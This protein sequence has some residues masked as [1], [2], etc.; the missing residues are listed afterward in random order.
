[1]HTS[2]LLVHNSETDSV[3]S[4]DLKGPPDERIDKWLVDQDEFTFQ[5]E[6][7]LT[8]SILQIVGPQTH[9][10]LHPNQSFLDFSSLH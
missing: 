5:F 10:E 4:Q 3:T 8:P 2:K 1:M 7:F 9:K 6:V